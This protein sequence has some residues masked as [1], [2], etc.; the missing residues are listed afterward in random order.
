MGGENGL[1]MALRTYKDL[2]VW[3]KAM[4]LLVDVYK[5]TA[6]YP[7]EERFGLAA[8]T[9]K[10][11]VSIPSNIAEGYARKTRGEYVRFLDIAYASTAELETQ[12]IAGD[13]LGYI[14][15]AERQLFDR[16]AEVERMLAALRARLDQRPQGLEPSNPR[17]LEP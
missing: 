5:V 16:H 2:L 15:K 3:Q 13:R 7:R 12:L 17:T 1:A 9:R 10:S 6:R 8:H 4:D 14:G 11:A